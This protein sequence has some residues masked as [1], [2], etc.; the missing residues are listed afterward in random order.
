MDRVERWFIVA[1][2]TMF[3]VLVGLGIISPLTSTDSLMKASYAQHEQAPWRAPE[4]RRWPPG[5]V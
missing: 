2:A 1:T 4:P 5:P 3:F